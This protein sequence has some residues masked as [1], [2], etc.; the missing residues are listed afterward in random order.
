MKSKI[1][2]F[3]FTFLPMMIYAQVSIEDTTF[4]WT[5]FDYELNA[6]NTL[7]W[8]TGVANDTVTQNF[9]GKV[10]E[11]KYLRVTLLPEYGGRIL[12][13]IYK[14]TGHEQLYRNPVGLPYGHG[15][16]NFYY[17]WLM[18]YGG[19]FPTFPESEHSKA[20]LLPWDYEELKISSDTV[21]IKMSLQD[22]V[23][24]GKVGKFWYGRTDLTCEYVVTLVKGE[25]ALRTGIALINDRD[26][27][28]T[29]EYWTCTTLAPGSEPEN[30]R[31]NGETEMVMPYSKIE[32][33]P[34]WNLQ[35]ME[36]P[37]N[38]QDNIYEF[39]NLKYY[40]NWVTDGIIY[41]RKEVTKN[42]WGAINHENEEGLIRISKNDITTDIK[43][44]CWKY[45]ESVTVNAFENPQNPRRPYIELWGGHSKTFGTPTNISANSSKRWTAIYAPT[46]GLSNISSASQQII[47]DFYI[48]NDADFAKIEFV[49]TKPEINHR[50]EVKTLG[51]HNSVIL[52]ETILPDLNENSFELDLTDV[53]WSHGDSLNCTI[54]DDDETIVF[55]ESV[56]FDTTTVNI[57]NDSP[58]PDN[59][60]LKQNYP[61]PFNGNTTIEY[62]I[63]ELSKVTIE[64]YNSRGQK[65]ETL[66]NQTKNAGKYSVN[67]LPKRASGVYFYRIMAK[68][69]NK[70]FVATKKLI[71]LK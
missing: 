31:A 14:P 3:F 34:W 50:L 58:S 21:R 64:I 52:N 17:D 15:D 45:S 1:I 61:N 48:N 35:S 12:S 37:I 19:I 67:W 65:I 28:V 8:V 44:W 4:S 9:S 43:I 20:W 6:D 27:E 11:N 16:G 51:F 57:A 42:F 7:N 5:T 13:M 40:K 22:T 24:L 68:N 36:E 66:V 60:S 70:P 59:F 39:K 18:V 29:Y 54:Y 71:Y 47:A 56:A 53:K 33:M 62:S 32:I 46:D 63:K 49:T 2:C 41:P 55:S 26:E 69:K 25:K 30:P 38:K 23:D 10:I